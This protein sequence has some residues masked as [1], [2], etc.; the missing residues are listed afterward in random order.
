M[1]EKT[2]F[3]LCSI[4][5][6][7]RTKDCGCVSV[8]AFRKMGDGQQQKKAH[9][10][11]L[12]QT[13]CEYAALRGPGGREPLGLL[14]QVEVTPVR[15]IDEDA[16][17]QLCLSVPAASRKQS[18]FLMNA[19][20]MYTLHSRLSGGTLKMLSSDWQGFRLLNRPVVLSSDMPCMGEGQVPILFGDFG[21]VYIQ[22]AGRGEMQEQSHGNH[23]S[24]IVC[25]M[26]GYM[27]CELVNREAVKGIKMV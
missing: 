26:E 6:V 21:S 19:S 10:E 24:N 11:R 2:L 20:T 15:D 3:D 5:D 22:R 18:V 14:Y 16:I 1:N 7:E 4:A 13:G 27:T 23:P 17:L 12:L 8:M 9:M 25:T